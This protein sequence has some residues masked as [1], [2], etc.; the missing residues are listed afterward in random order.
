GN[1]RVVRRKLNPVLAVALRSREIARVNQQVRP[2]RREDDACARGFSA[3]AV[4]SR[5]R[6]GG[7]DRGRGGRRGAR[8]GRFIAPVHDRQILNATRL[9]IGSR[10][11]GLAVRPAAEL[12]LQPYAVRIPAGETHDVVWVERAERIVGRARSAADVDLLED[13]SALPGSG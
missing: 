4:R 11:P 8:P 3:V 12:N 5:G 2:E 13:H 9:Y 6:E 7:R 1:K 10:H